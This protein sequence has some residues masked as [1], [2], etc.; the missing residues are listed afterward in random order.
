MSPV[1]SSPARWARSASPPAAG[2]IS[3]PALL[4]ACAS[5]RSQIAGRGRSSPITRAPQLSSTG[6]GPTSAPAPSTT[7]VR[8]GRDSQPGC[9]ATARTA[10]AHDGSMTPPLTHASSRRASASPLSRSPRY[11]TDSSRSASPVPVTVAAASPPRAGAD[12][13]ASSPASSPSRPMTRIRRCSDARPSLATDTA[14]CREPSPAS[15]SPRKCAGYPVRQPVSRSA[16]PAAAAS[17]RR[18]AS[19]TTARPSAE[20]LRRPS[21]ETG[22]ATAPALAVAHHQTIMANRGGPDHR[23]RRTGPAGRARLRSG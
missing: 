21:S 2:T 23:R 1:R 19:A 11:G 14:A 10:S 12:T 16:A 3:V 15:I 4:R 18:S 22:K 13:S 7:T 17:T 9:A 6:S 8:P 20:V 5:T